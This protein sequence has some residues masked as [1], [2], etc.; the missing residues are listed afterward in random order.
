[1]MWYGPCGIGTARRVEG[2]QKHHQA[3]FLKAFPDRSGR[4]KGV[5]HI[6]PIADGH[7]VASTGWPSVGA[8]HLGEYLDVSPTGKLITMRV[9]DWW[10]REGDVFRE[11]WV[12]IDIPELLLQMGVD[13]FAR[14]REQIDNAAATKPL[15]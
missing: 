13:L 2:F 14:M 12:L 9:A 10:R 4:G 5:G 11:N 3:P 1:M 15:M 6:A 8:T 7:C